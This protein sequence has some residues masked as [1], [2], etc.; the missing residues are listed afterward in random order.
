MIDFLVVAVRRIDTTFH[1]VLFKKGIAMH[2]C[3][4][5]IEWH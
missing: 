3:M 4:I 2:S 1:L 5:I